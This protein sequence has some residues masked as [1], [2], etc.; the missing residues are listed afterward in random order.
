MKLQIRNSLLNGICS[1]FFLVAVH[2]GTAAMAQT[3]APNSDVDSLITEFYS[4]IWHRADYDAARRVA[5]SI[6]K[7]GK[8]KNDPQLQAR[9]LIRLAYIEIAFGKWR[10]KWE[11]KLKKCET[12]IVPSMKLAHA[13]YLTFS[14]HIKGKWQG[15]LDVGIKRV[16]CAT[17]IAREIQNDELL[18]QCHVLASEIRGF[19][20]DNFQ[21]FKH[22]C[23]AKVVAIDI[24]IEWCVCAAL[25]QFV[26][27]H[28]QTG[29]VD[30][31]KKE[32][33]L[34]LSY[35]PENLVANRILLCRGENEEYLEELLQETKEMEK[36]PKSLSISD[37]IG[38]NYWN[39]G[40]VYYKRKEYERSKKYVEAAIPNLEFSRNDSVLESCRYTLIAIEIKLDRVTKAQLDELTLAIARQKYKLNRPE[41][42]LDIANAYASL[43]DEENFRNW[44]HK[45]VTFSDADNAIS[46]N[47][48]ESTARDF[49]DSE[50]L[51][52]AQQELSRQ[53]QKRSTAIYVF[54]LLLGGLATVTTAVFFTRQRTIAKQ[55]RQLE[56]L[57]AER[58]ASLS[59]AMEKAMSADEA[60]SEFLARMNHEIRNPLTAILG[61]IEILKRR[62]HEPDFDLGHCMDGLAAS[63]YHL[64]DL[65]NDILE[66]SKIETSDLTIAKHPFDVREAVESVTRIVATK[67]EEKSLQM[68]S[69]FKISDK[70]LLVGDESRF[71]QIILNL[72][73][74]AIKFTDQGNVTID[75]LSRSLDNERVILEVTI[76]DTGRGIPENETNLVM[77]KFTFSSENRHD[78]GTGLGLYIS[79]LLVEKMGGEIRL[80]SE[81]NQGTIAY[82]S[83]PFSRT[84]RTLETVPTDVGLTVNEN[85]VMVIDDQQFVCQS[86]CLQLEQLGL[87]TQSTNDP[88]QAFE[89]IKE[90]RPHIVLL[91]LRMPKRSGYEVFDQI[92]T[93][94]PRPIVLAMS[95]DATVETKSRCEEAG[96]DE[97]LIKPFKM[98]ELEKRITAFRNKRT[99]ITN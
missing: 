14:G 81:P 12:I 11:Q 98:D 31:V 92:A 33:E 16:L 67:A 95:G 79:K 22:S 8:E 99:E 41:Q 76:A 28:H 42:A 78:G 62:R 29:R 39:L 36:Q 73:S 77:E 23:R 50:M 48:I 54:L 6:V 38:T 55:N 7:M 13:E 2:S 53:Q 70:E 40:Y 5:E 49:W 89:L 9:G 58:T 34:L 72:A 90:W 25:Q 66:V 86:I 27:L 82:V 37:R 97:F 63:G 35:W 18:V 56:E 96:F 17:Q 52:R 87:E 64:H 44:Q 88:E 85:R 46:W 4:Y 84:D 59:A 51:A 20:R 93:L 61:F 26:L 19:Q 74:N 24:G 68:H 47:S 91:D 10:N 21:A 45:S 75:I 94:H 60:K 83:I 43:G 32:M 65:V 1:L 80:E 3:S 71:K 30:S 15:E 69:N 57:I